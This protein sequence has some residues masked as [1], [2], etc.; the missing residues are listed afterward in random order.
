M[1]RKGRE[2]V[3]ACRRVERTGIVGGGPEGRRVVVAGAWE[4]LLYVRLRDRF[5]CW[6]LVTTS[7]VRSVRIRIRYGQPQKTNTV[8]HDRLQAWIDPR[9][10]RPRSARSSCGHGIMQGCEACNTKFKPIACYSRTM[11]SNMM[12]PPVCER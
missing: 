4:Y 8:L 5:H 12:K 6:T 9:N 11:D 7:D 2:K 1:E 3:V 10:Q